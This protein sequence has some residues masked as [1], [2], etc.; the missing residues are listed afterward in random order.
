[1]LLGALAPASS[2]T[3]RRAARY[4]I[5]LTSGYGFALGS[6]PTRSLAA[7]LREA[8]RKPWLAAAPAGLND[9]Q[10][11]AKGL[12]SL[13]DRDRRVRCR[14]RAAERRAPDRGGRGPG[15]RRSATSCASRGAPSRAP[16]CRLP[17]RTSGR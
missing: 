15:A 7:S 9:S 17:S 2:Q 8:D 16:P 5:G 10:P 11:L 4:R 1:M 12:A 14:A 3:R 13:Q 6:S